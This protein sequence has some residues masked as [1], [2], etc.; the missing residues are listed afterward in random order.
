[1]WKLLKLDCGMFRSRLMRFWK[2]VVC[3]FVVVL[4]MLDGLFFF[5]YWGDE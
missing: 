4:V 2:W 5:F 3:F 1:M